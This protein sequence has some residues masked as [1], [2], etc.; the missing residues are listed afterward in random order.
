MGNELSSEG[1]GMSGV[2]PLQSQGPDHLWR[3]ELNRGKGSEGEGVCLL[4]RTFGKGMQ[5]KLCRAGLKVSL[6]P[7]IKIVTFSICCK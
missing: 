1:V 6:L 7:V 5:D 2:L 4:I 3:L